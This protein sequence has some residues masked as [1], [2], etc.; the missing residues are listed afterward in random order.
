MPSDWRARRTSPPLGRGDANGTNRG[1]KR[2]IMDGLK[3][4]PIH[5]FEKID[6]PD[7]LDVKIE[8]VQQHGSYS[9]LDAQEPTIAVPGRCDTLTYALYS[10]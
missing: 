3:T 10:R 6:D 5:T 8:D 4:E 7:D 9:W 2:E 1:P